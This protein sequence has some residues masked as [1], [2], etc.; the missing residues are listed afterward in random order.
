MARP[1]PD[2]QTCGA[3]CFPLYDVG[4]HPEVSDED[5]RCLS[6]HWRGRLVVVSGSTRA[7]PTRETADGTPC[8]ALRGRLG[9]SVRCS[10]YDSRPDACVDFAPGS[11]RCR[12]ARR[13][14]GVA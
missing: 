2:C 13:D 12:D 14:A 6:R 1:K 3:C 8:A 9:V 10:I 4:H 7:L 11:N 5:A